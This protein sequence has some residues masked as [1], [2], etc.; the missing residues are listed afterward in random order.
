[1][2]WLMTVMER[3]GYPGI[4]LI[5]ALENVFPPI[6]SEVVLPFAGFL[7]RHGG[8]TLPGVITAST[9]GSVLGALIL[10]GLG[11]LIGSERIYRL[12][13]HRFSPIGVNGIARSGRWFAK[14]GPWAVFF[15]RMIPTVR[16][17]ISIPA[18]ISRMPLNVFII[19]TIFGTLIWN[20]ILICTGAAL[21]AAWP[22]AGRWIG[23]YDDFFLWIALATLAVY[24][25]I[26]IVQRGK[27]L[28][29]D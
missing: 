15:G 13:R 14:Y 25:I 29:K 27:T 17:L 11:Y 9:L 23:Y 5:V 4:A 28:I 26:K 24:L 6:P 18:G 7:T 2:H 1:M 8:L 19:C 21:G 12:T 10:Y 16:S 22:E 3:L 20:T